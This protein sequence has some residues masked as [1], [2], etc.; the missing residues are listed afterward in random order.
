MVRPA[1][2]RLIETGPAAQAAG[3]PPRALESRNRR[4][5]VLPERVNASRKSSR[6]PGLPLHKLLDLR[7]YRRQQGIKAKLLH[8]IRRVLGNVLELEQVW[9]WQPQV[10]DL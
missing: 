4:L 3:R 2:R 1:P 6:R 10:V 8:R 5:P 9:L 7:L